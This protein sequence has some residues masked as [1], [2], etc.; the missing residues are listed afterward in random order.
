MSTLYIRGKSIWIAFTDQFGTYRRRRLGIDSVNGTIPKDALRLKQ[1]IDVEVANHTWGVKNDIRRVS[2]SELRDEF[3]AFISGV[4]DLKTV[5]LYKLAAGQLM[6]YIG[7]VPIATRTATGKDR[8]L[9]AAVIVGPASE[10]HTRTA[11]PS[12][13]CP[14]G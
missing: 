8:L 12:C 2:L 13:S 1:K 14:G 6:E 5:Y 7:D 11:I 10:L 3:V 9:V 4:R